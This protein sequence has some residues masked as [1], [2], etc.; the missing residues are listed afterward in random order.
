MHCNTVYAHFYHSLPC[1]FYN[2]R[3][4][5]H[6][7][8]I[9]IPLVSPSLRRTSAPIQFTTISDFGVTLCCMFRDSYVIQLCQYFEGTYTSESMNPRP[10]FLSLQYHLRSLLS[11]VTLLFLLFHIT[12]TFIYYPYT[13]CFTISSPNQ[14]TYT[15]YHCI[16]CVGDTR[17]SLLFG[18]WVA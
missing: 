4:Q 16:G 8:T 5:I 13:T 7:S 6:I 17:D 15:I 1:C 9:H 11:F 2:F 18:C 3:L 14:C 10:C 12:N